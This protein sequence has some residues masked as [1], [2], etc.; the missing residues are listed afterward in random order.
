MTLEGLLYSVLVENLSLVS[1][2][3][4]EPSGGSTME[5]VRSRRQASLQWYGTELTEISA[6]AAKRQSLCCVAR[7][8]S[9]RGAQLHVMLCFETALYARQPAPVDKRD[10]EGVIGRHSAS[11]HIVLR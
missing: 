8:C 3:I 5:M 1:R 11:L 9:I 2:V 7:V 6:V 4:G 10:F